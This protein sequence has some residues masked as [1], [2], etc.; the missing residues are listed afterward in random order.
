MRP[1]EKRRP[2]ADQA[3]EAAAV[4]VGRTIP[5]VRHARRPWRPTDRRASDALDALCSTERPTIDYSACGLD[6][7][8]AD[9][10]ALGVALLVLDRAEQAA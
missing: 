8:Y 5:T 6:L 3:R 2:R 9:R 10:R 1:H 7:D 4:Q